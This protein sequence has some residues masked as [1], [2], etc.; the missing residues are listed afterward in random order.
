M[1]QKN[2]SGQYKSM[3]IL[4]TIIKVL[5]IPINLLLAKSLTN[6]AMLAANGDVV[7]VGYNVQRGII[8]VIALTVI[9]LVGNMILKRLV[10]HN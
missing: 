1:K 6:I 2:L 5:C 3:M 9:Q 8:L 4:S 10:V 7:N